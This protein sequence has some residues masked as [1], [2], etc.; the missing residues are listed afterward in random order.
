MIR[1]GLTGNVASGKSTVARLWEGAGVPVIDADQLAREAV[2]PG[3]RGLAAV[4]ER[5]GAGVLQE[6]G[7]L[8][9]KALGTVV[10]RDPSERRALE[11]IVHP[12]VARLRTRWEEARRGE[13]HP[14]VVAEIPLLFEAGMEDQV[15]VVVFVDAPAEVRRERLIRERGMDPAEADRVME[16]QEDPAEKRRR[17][18]FVLENEGTEEELAAAALDLLRRI[19]REVGG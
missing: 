17:S 15:E 8:D 18:H 11:A 9:R 2:A 3:T 6:D 19:R 10:F 7:S 5:F 12:E 16:A 4:V 13:G 1:V 14:L